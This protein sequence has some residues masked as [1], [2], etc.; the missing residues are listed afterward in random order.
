MEAQINVGLVHI[1][2]VL[3]QQVLFEPLP[4]LLAAEDRRRLSPLF[5]RIS[6]P[7]GRLRLD[8]DARQELTDP[9]GVQA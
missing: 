6:T 4:R 8:M 9:P 7:L 2:A 5:Y 1:S 3:L